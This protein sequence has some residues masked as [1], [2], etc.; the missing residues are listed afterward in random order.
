MNK[1]DTLL[2][3]IIAREGAKD[4]HS[5]NDSGGRTKFGIS[6]KWHPEAWE[7]GP[8]SREQA[9]QIYLEQYIINPGIHRIKPDFVQGQLVDYAVLSGPHRA[10]VALQNV[11]QIKEDGIIGPVTLGMLG[12]LDAREINNKLVDRRV[13]L[14]A[15]L[16]QQR[17]KDLVWLFGWI[18][19]A[20]KFRV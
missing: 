15:R 4:T 2:E 5:P 11:L 10:I 14:M 8:P 3:E 17:P 1:I 6:Q 19:R 7:H 13:L 16:V 9:E 12:T 18:S 20:L